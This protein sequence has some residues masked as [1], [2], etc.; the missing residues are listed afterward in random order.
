MPQGE[1]KP[2]DIEVL[3]PLR[4]ALGEC[5]VWDDARQLLLVADI[6]GCAIHVLDPDSGEV[7]ETHCFPSE[8]GSFGLARSGRWVVAVRDRVLSYDPAT[9]RHEELCRPGP[10][11]PT[12]RFNDGKIG[13]DGAFWVGSMDDRTPRLPTGSL[14]RITGSGAVTRITDGLTTSNGLA[15]SADGRT[16]FHADSGQNWLDAWEFDP[17]TGAATNRRRLASEGSTFTAATGKPDGAATD[18]AGNYW[19]AGVFGARLNRFSA[20]GK[21]LDHIALPL[22]AP[23]MPCFGGPDMRTLF[24]SSLRHPIGPERIAEWPL[25]GAVL[26]LRMEAEGVPVARFQD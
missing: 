17:S 10:E 7:R 18:R 14:Y 4:C 11:L 15:W 25:S 12:N 3:G 20:E 5:P 2:M 19:S 26:R 22:F 24:V 21:I 8:V 1:T 9:R 13:P 23:T 16:M 6:I